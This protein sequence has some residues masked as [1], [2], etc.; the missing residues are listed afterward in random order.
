M[1]I[2]LIVVLLGT[3]F[4]GYIVYQ[5]GDTRIKFKKRDWE[6]ELPY[7]FMNDEISFVHN[8]QILKGY[9]REYSKEHFIVT[10]YFK[11]VKGDLEKEP[12]RMINKS[13]SM[14]IE[15]NRVELPPLIVKMSNLLENTS[16]VERKI[17]IEHYNRE[18]IYQTLKEERYMLLERN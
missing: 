10:D 1:L 5:E 15:Y 13:N 8:N 18:E 14:V 4:F 17:K 7:W 11:K 16:H 2:Y 12:T 9:L 3:T 6:A